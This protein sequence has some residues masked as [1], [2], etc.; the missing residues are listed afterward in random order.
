[1]SAKELLPGEL[2]PGEL[3]RYATQLKL[4]NIGIKG[5]QILKNSRVLCVGAGGLGSPLLMYLAAAGVGTLGIIDDDNLELSNLQRQILYQ[6]KYI[7]EPKTKIAQRQ[8]MALNPEIE[9]KI[10]PQR[11]I[12]QNALE[13]ISQYQIIADCSDNFS[14]R[15]LINDICFQTKIPFVSA[16]VSQYEGLC[17]TFLGSIGPCLRCLFPIP[18]Q[19]DIIPNCVTGGVLGVVPGLLGMIQ[20]TEIIKFLLQ[21]GDLLVKRVL[22]IDILQMN[23]REF[24]LQRNSACTI[25]VDTPATSSQHSYLPEAENMNAYIITPEELKELLA[26]NANIQL[27]DVRTAEKHEIFNIGGKLIP[28]QELPE[29]LHELDPNKPTV[30][31]CTM[32]GN[33]MR[34]LQYLLSV[35]FKDVRSLDGGMTLWQERGF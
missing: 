3:L 28:T 25:C 8:L 13:L 19:T 16:S 2:L 11:L 9:I 1:M 26:A 15:Y 10:Y 12:A 24:Q 30:T 29:R 23:F 18:P 27:I 7:G 4:D 35:G 17:T 33:S 22:S 14:T 21:L 31:Y 34:A 20:A 6:T 5:Q 32:G